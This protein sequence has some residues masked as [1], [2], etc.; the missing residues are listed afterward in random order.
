MWV[1][2]WC[3]DNGV[4][5]LE[6]WV[7]HTEREALA[8]CTNMIVFYEIKEPQAVVMTNVGNNI[9]RY[10]S[11]A[12]QTYNTLVSPAGEYQIGGMYAVMPKDPWNFKQEDWLKGVRVRTRAAKK[13]KVNADNA[14]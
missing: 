9:E 1:L 14:W 11:N 4:W 12:G 2:Q 10:R 7:Y 3:D 6:N 13:H 8:W 5:H